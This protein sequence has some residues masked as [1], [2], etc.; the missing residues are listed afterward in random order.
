L[1]PI[2]VIAAIMAAIAFIGSWF[3]EELPLLDKISD[4]D[5][6]VS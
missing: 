5:E 3:L 2:F 6:S 1:T 4:E